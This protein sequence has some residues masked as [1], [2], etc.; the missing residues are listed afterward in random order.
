MA[1]LGQLTEEIV[2]AHFIVSDD[3][4]AVTPQTPRD[5]DWAST[6]SFLNLS[7]LGGGRPGSKG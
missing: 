5:P 4:P 6:S 7:V 2:L 1:E 3:D